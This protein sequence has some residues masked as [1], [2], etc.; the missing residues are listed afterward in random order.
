[1]IQTVVKVIVLLLLTK[2]CFALP[3]DHNQIMQLQADSADLNQQTHRGVYI[4]DVQIDQGSTHVRAA[5]AITEGNETNQLI[6]AIIK[7][8]QVAQAHYWTLTAAD[9][10]PLHAYADTIYYYPERHSIELIGNAKVEQGKDFFSAP[11]IIYDTLHQHVVSK[12]DGK[13]RTVIIMH[14]GKNS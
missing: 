4:G 11:Q 14:Q 12:N 8:N 9:K 7:G 13:T 5:Q 1:M 6:K 2:M 10:P 3:E